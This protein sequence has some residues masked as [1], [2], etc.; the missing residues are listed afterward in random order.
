[1]NSTTS[2]EQYQPVVAMDSDGDFV[3]TW[4]S[5][6]QDGGYDGVY[7]QRY[8]ASGAAQGSEF[9][10]N[11][12]TTDNQS[13]P[14]IAMA[15][16]GDFVVTWESYTQ[17]GSLHGIYVQRYNASGVAQG[18]EFKVNTETSNSQSTPALAMDKNGNFVVVWQSNLQDGENNGIYAQRY[19]G[20]FVTSIQNAA[21]LTSA[22]LY[23]NP[24]QDQVFVNLEGEVD[25]K[26][27]DASG[28]LIKE[29]VLTNQS[30]NV[31]DLKSGLYMIQLTQAGSSVMKK[32]VVQ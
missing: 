24:A 10:V 1:V 19:T 18:A 28:A 25:V 9:L 2:S 5:S 29:T 4:T 32:L 22:D 11:T 30:F 7:A 27:L 3:V 20:G 21:V 14:S 31:S 6:S 8:N 15:E 13:A 23:P 26:V 17:D 16:N 12:T